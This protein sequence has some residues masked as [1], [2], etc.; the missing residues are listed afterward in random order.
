MREKNIAS[1]CSCSRASRHSIARVSQDLNAHE[2]KALKSLKSHHAPCHSHI[3]QTPRT[4]D[5]DSWA[6]RQL[7]V[8]RWGLSMHSWGRPRCTMF[9][10]TSSPGA[11]ARPSRLNKPLPHPHV[12]ASCWFGTHL[13]FGLDVMFVL[14]CTTA[15]SCSFSR[16]IH[17]RRQPFI[18]SPTLA[19]Q[20][21][22]S[23]T[24]FPSR[25][26]DA[27]KPSAWSIARATDAAR[28][29]CR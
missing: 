6:R 10:C 12:Q 29:H 17:V 28:R 27:G 14:T 3:T 2:L 16:L 5:G 9:L 4:G 22:D 7:R 20:G 13:S 1:S 18:V 23:W 8:S 26:K 15:T 11:R 21:A 19:R 24:S 25:V